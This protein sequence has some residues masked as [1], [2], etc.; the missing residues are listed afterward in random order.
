MGEACCVGGKKGEG[1]EGVEKKKKG[2]KIS[3]D[4]V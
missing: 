1:I 3:C 2:M 4:G